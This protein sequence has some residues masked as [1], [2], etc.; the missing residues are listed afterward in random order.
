[1]IIRRDGGNKLLLFC[2]LPAPPSLLLPVF[3][4]LITSSFDSRSLSVRSFL[5]ICVPRPLAACLAT[6]ALS[7]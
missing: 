4:S 1:M 7:A 5:A 6:R 2:F 3:A